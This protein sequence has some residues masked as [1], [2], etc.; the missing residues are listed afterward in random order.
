MT[1]D[2]DLFRLRVF[3]TVV[4]RNGFSAAARRLHLA[5]S[6]VSRHMSELE[7]ACGVRLLQYDGRSVQLSASGREVY[8][9]ALTMLAEQDKLAK[10]LGD[11]KRGRSGRIRLGASMALEQEYF[12]SDVVAPFC[13]A[14]D[15]TMLSLRFGHSRREAQAVLD[16]ELDLAYV[17]RWDLPDD[18]H[19]ESLHEAELA[20]LVAPDHPLAREELVAVEEVMKAGLI[21]APLAAPEAYFY[22]EVLRKRGIDKENAQLEVDGQQARLMAAAAGLGVMATFVPRYARTAVCEKLTWLSVEGNRTT[23]DLGLVRQPG[24]VTTNYTNALAS[25][26]RELSF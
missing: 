15:R 1:L 11:L 13:R 22:R 12:L 24:D 6:T 10:S 4:D 14:H 8:Q 17:I 21:T 23:V 7:R 25:W 3:A 9:V 26:L 19:F 20:F 16:R 5:Q 18:A 2:L